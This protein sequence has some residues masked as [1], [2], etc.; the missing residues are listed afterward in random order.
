[1]PRRPI[2]RIQDAVHG[3]MEFRD[4]ETVVIDILRTPEI[5]RLRRIRQ[6]GLAHLV[7]PGS[8]H[9]RLAHCLGSAFLAVRFG[10][11]LK[12]AC[13]NYLVKHLSVS[14]SAIR[15]CAVAALC[16]D[17]GHGPLSH[18]WER[19]VIGD[20]YDRAQWIERF[21]LGSEEHQLADLKWHELASQA[22]L[23]DKDSQ[24]H[25]LLEAHETGFSE[26]VRYLLR[27]QYYLPYV[28]RLLS[29]DVDVDRADFLLRDAHQSGVAY[30]RYD[31]E[32]LIS[33]CT[34]GSTSE[35]KLVVGF[36]LRKSPPVIEQFLVA[37]RALY[38]T[39]YYHKTVRS[40]EGMVG[41]FL[42]RLKDIIHDIDTRNLTSFVEPVVKIVSGKTI[43]TKELLALD[44]H[45][46]WVFIEN[47]VKLPGVD[48][49]ARDLGNRILAR[50]LFKIVPCDS[51]RVSEFLRGKDAYEQIFNTIQPFCPGK[52]ESYL[53]VDTAKFSMLRDQAG[54]RAYF[55]DEERTAQLVRDHPQFRHHWGDPDELVRLFTLREAVDAVR[56]LI[57][58]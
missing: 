31:L 54:Q 20:D 43:S 38:N 17:L 3:L 16:H 57:E 28:P 4:M 29:S 52:S 13:L 47:V 5:Q 10:R 8:E 41:L 46:L 11:H 14:E 19:E 25:Q 24:L 36:D 55:V 58:R 56:R 23:A 2:Q 18:P 7:F 37:R 33:T 35:G 21:G 39:V 32:W 22:L 6:T 44:D 48:P 34:V 53:V 12:E 42:R 1:M 45:A 30:G 40:A 49:T 15:D 50:D 9:S 26:R 27:G 51:Q